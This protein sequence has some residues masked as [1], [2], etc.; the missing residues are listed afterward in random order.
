MLSQF[1]ESPFLNPIY[2]KDLAT[3]TPFV[4]LDS[5]EYLVGDGVL[6][7][8]NTKKLKIIFCF[9]T[10]YGL[11]EAAFAPFVGTVVGSSVLHVIK[12]EIERMKY[13][14]T[15]YGQ[16]IIAHLEIENPMVLLQYGLAWNP[17]RRKK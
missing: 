10:E 8:I 9:P 1:H 3:K 4:V 16:S 15:T 2:M 5:G 6:V 12:T 13:D 17:P 7:A 14:I 11:G